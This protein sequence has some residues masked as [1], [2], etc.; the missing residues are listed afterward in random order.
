MATGHSPSA[1]NL[2]PVLE[3]YGGKSLKRIVAVGAAIL[4]C[5]LTATTLIRM[6]RP[7]YLGLML[8][9]FVVGLG[10]ALGYMNTNWNAVHAKVE[11]CAGGVRLLVRG[12]VAWNRKGHLSRWAPGTVELPWDRILKV[13]VGKYRKVRGPPFDHVAI[14]T[15]DGN[16]SEIPFF[17]LSEAEA[18]RFATIARGFVEAVEVDVDFV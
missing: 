17:F 1:G 6:F 18:Q 7:D 15:T 2:G 13:R 16:D 12:G 3:A 9:V 5:G 14:R 8:C 11:V 4:G 10:I